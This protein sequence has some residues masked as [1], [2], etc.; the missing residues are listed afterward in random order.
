MTEIL[1]GI[2]IARILDHASGY[3]INYLK[4]KGKRPTL[5][6][7]EAS[8]NPGVLAYKKSL[9]RKANQLGIRV[10]GCSWNIKDEVTNEDIIATIKALNDTKEI[11]A[12]FPLKPFDIYTENQQEIWNAID[13]NKDVDRVSNASLGGLIT[14][15]NSAP[16]TAE[17]CFN[18]LD[19]HGI[20]CA[21]KDVLVI[22]RSS[23]VGLPAALLAT[24]LDATVTVAHSK[25]KYLKERVINSDIIISA[26]GK[27]NLITTDMVKPYH[28]IID[29][30]INEVDGKIVGD[31]SP[32]VNGLVKA[33][34]P[35][36]G[37][38]GAVTTSILMYRVVTAAMEARQNSDE[39]N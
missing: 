23:T 10:L 33:L 9:I 35:V 13:I 36:P 31:V 34:T 16:C 18:I 5:V 20:S 8:N 15:F 30:G 24:K 39:I 26:A 4:E 29:V 37:G 14:G 6:L 27:P 22:G 7:L 2:E 38:V 1:S 11:D 3:Y 19:Y 21:G 17:A 32:D 28:T 25:S 12:I